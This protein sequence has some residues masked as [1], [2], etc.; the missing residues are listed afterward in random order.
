MGLQPTAVPVD[1]DRD[2]DR[3]AGDHAGLAHPLIARVEDQIGEGFGQR[4]AGKL[5]QAR[6]QPPVHRTDRGSRKAVAAQLIGDRLHPRFREGKLLRVETPCTYISASAATSARR[7]LVLRQKRFDV[8]QWPKP[9]ASRWVR[10]SASG[11]CTNCSRTGCAPSSARAIP[12]LP[13]SSPTSSGSISIR[14]PMQC[15]VDR[16]KEPDPSA[17]PYPAGTADQTRALP[18]HDA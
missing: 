18:D 8:G 10:C 7:S 4:A 3:R 13:P 11:G 6:V 15:A 9:S 1:A 12:A 2:Q 17:R 16:R 5:R 14:R